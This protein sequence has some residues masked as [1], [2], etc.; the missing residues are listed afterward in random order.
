M[1]LEVS[2]HGERS[3]TAA[4]TRSDVVSPT[5]RHLCNVRQD[6]LYDAFRAA[7]NLFNERPTGLEEDVSDWPAWTLLRVEDLQLER[8]AE[9]GRLVDTTSKGGAR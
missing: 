1:S 8:F 2:R 6:Q 9:D 7:P 4:R 5:L 3:G